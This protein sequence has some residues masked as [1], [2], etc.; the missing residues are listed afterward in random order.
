MDKDMEKRIQRM[1][2]RTWDVIGGD[3][4][5]VLEEQGED[6]VMPQADVVEV[7]CDADYMLTHGNDKEAYEVWKQLPFLKQTEVV[8]KV[9]TYSSYG[10]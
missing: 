1:A 7:V 6:P 5:T 3:M 2:L 4:L 8:S 10:W 9:F